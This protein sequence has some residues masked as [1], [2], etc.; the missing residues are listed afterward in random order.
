MLHTVLGVMIQGQLRPFR[1]EHLLHGCTLRVMGPITES[2]NFEVRI[3][4]AELS[5]PGQGSRVYW[6]AGGA[7]APQVG[8]RFREARLIIND[9]NTAF[10]RL[11]CPERIKH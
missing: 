8:K 10:L 6:F 5:E 11:E 3:P 2:D 7:E 4:S 9:E 1:P